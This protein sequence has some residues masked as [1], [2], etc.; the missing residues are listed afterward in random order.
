MWRANL[1]LNGGRPE[2]GWSYK[3]QLKLN[4]KDQVTPKLNTSLLQHVWW[5]NF[6]ICIKMVIKMNTFMI[7]IAHQSC[8]SAH[9]RLLIFQDMSDSASMMRRTQSRAV[10]VAKWRSETA[11][12]GSVK[13]HALKVVSKDWHKDWWWERGESEAPTLHTNWRRDWEGKK[14]VNATN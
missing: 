2:K 9:W 14:K 4:L 10:L 13:P 1:H 3:P 7:W 11:N 5:C 6:S 8:L 12:I